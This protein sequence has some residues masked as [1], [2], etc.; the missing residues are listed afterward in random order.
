MCIVS[1][2][3]RTNDLMSTLGSHHLDLHH[4][5]HFKHIQCLPCW[6]AVVCHVDPLLFA[7]STC[8][9][10]PHW[11]K[12]PLTP[13]CHLDLCINPELMPGLPCTV[14]TCIV[15]CRLYL[16]LYSPVHCKNKCIYD[17]KDQFRPVLNQSCNHQKTK[18]DTKDWS[19]AVW[20]SF[21]GFLEL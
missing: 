8:H 7:M 4:N 21:W 2:L 18:T 5:H 20:S 10:L 3:I 9:C 15:G 13:C 19:W 1:T 6:P 16:S 11:H 12:L 17:L 14:Y